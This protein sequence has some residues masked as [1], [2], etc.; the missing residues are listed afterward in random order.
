MKKNIVNKIIPVLLSLMII[1]VASYG[2]EKSQ[3]TSMRMDFC[4]DFVNNTNSTLV[5]AILDHDDGGCFIRIDYF[6]AYSTSGLPPKFYPHGLEIVLTNA[7][8]TTPAGFVSG[9]WFPAPTFSTTSIRWKKT[10]VPG[11]VNHIPPSTPLIIK[12]YISITPGASSVTVD[13]HEL[14]GHLPGTSGIDDRFCFKDFSFTKEAKNYSIGLDNS[15]CTGSFTTICISPSPSPTA[16]ITWYKYTGTIPPCPTT[17]P[18]STS[19]VVDGGGIGADCYNTQRLEQTTCYVAV[20]QD[21]CW[22]YVSN[23]RTIEVCPG[24]PS[25]TIVATPAS[26]FDLPTVIDNVNH[27]CTSWRGQLCLD[28]STFPCLT[29]IVRWEKRGR[30]GN[31]SWTSW[32]PIS[33]SNNKICIPTGRLTT[34]ACSTTYEFRAILQNAC[35][36]ATPTWTI[37]IDRPPDPGSITANPPSPLCFDSSTKLTHTTKCGRVVEWEMREE[38]DPPCSKKYG[39]WVVISGS[40]GTP[41]WWTNDLQRTT[42]YRVRV[43][44]G[45]CP[46]VNENPVYSQVITVIVKPELTVTIKAVN[47]NTVLCAKVKLQAETSWDSPCNYPVTYQWHRDGLPIT[48]PSTLSSY[49]PTVGGNYYVVV[50]GKACGKVKSNVITICN[51]PLLTITG[52]CCVCPGETIYLTANVLWSPKN[53]KSPSC[54]YKWSTGETTQTISVT[55]AGTYSV[56][57]ICGDCKL[58]QSFTVD[59]CIPV[60]DECECGEWEDYTRLDYELSGVGPSITDSA[61]CGD[62]KYILIDTKISISNFTGNFICKGTGCKAEYEWQILDPSGDPIIDQNG[63]PIKGSGKIINSEFTASMTGDYTLTIQPI[64]GSENCRPCKITFKVIKWRKLIQKG[65]LT[66]EDDPVNIALN[67]ERKRMAD[68]ELGIAVEQWY[69][70][71]NNKDWLSIMLELHPDAVK[72]VLRVG[73]KLIQKGGELDRTDLTIIE[74]TMRILDEEIARAP[75]GLIDKSLKRLRSSI[76]MKWDQIMENFT[77]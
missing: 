33:N 48:T 15:V 43:E 51:P 41:V 38:L 74:K 37:V 76:G 19:W 46:T 17:T 68:T 45:A 28:P 47:G 40:Q 14:T 44:N 3:R 32:T 77:K 35:G 6:H 42:Q 24:R 36:K 22:S 52:D 30:V 5:T 67:K 29:K 26:G 73:R 53:C 58:T 12:K 23:V 57:V 25:V 56:T 50:D 65:I 72:S 60:S 70:E 11:P 4:A 2:Q 63:D 21:G 8:F 31:G 9:A 64:C 34:K 18:L 27:A 62:T 10:Y 69:A 7:T 66:G 54:T 1:S 75:E 49:S 59:D 39:A 16:Q 71:L 20:I 13:L 61:S 55:K